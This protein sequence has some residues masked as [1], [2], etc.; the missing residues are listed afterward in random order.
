[1]A[2]EVALTRSPREAILVSDPVP[3]LDTAR[4]EHMQ[5]IAKVMAAS[6]LI[7]ETLRREGPKNNQV[8]LS[9]E[10]VFANCFLVVNQAVR[11]NMDPFAVVQ[12]CSV[13][14]GR[15]MYEGKLVAAVLEA[16]LG[17]ELNYR[18]NDASGDALRVIVNATASDG[19]LVKD[20]NGNLKEVSGSV[21]E[22]KTTGAGT[23]WNGK[24]DRKMLTYRGAR[25]WARMF[26]PGTMLGVYSDDEMTD[27]AENARAERARP[28]ERLQGVVDPL[29]VS[30]PAAQAQATPD[31][32][33]SSREGDP[34]AQSRNDAGEVTPVA[35]PAEIQDPPAKAAAEAAGGRLRDE[36][37]D[38]APREEAR[39][40]STPV[41]EEARPKAPAPATAEEYRAHVLA[42]VTGA[43]SASALDGQWKSKEERALRSS[44]L[45]LKARSELEAIVA[46]RCIELKGGAT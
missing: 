22:W 14:Y 8:D 19:R 13:V 16:R 45:D 3:V 23:P 42:Y 40:A 18:W 25:E 12:C 39:P 21:G 10:Q 37:R 34:P 38:D 17:L 35:S 5:R 41:K 20:G 4:F 36:P 43:T 30:K 1:M 2:N 31:V 27:M 29:G 6:S 26:A 9:P 46:A 24:Q 7:P 44:L 11:W 33:K 28:V 32:A 15:L